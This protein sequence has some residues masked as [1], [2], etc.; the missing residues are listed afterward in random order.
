MKFAAYVAV[1]F[2]TF[3]HV[4]LVPF[5]ISVYMCVCFVCFCLILK[6]M[7]FYCYVY[8]FLLLCLCILI[9]MYVLFCIFCFIMLFYVFFVC[10][11]VLN[12]CQQVSTK[13]QLTN[14]SA[15]KRRI[16]RLDLHFSG[17]SHSADWYLVTTH[18]IPYV[19]EYLSVPA[20]FSD[21]LTLAFWTNRLSQKSLTNYH[22][23]LCKIPEEQQCHLHHRRSMKSCQL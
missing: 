5:F 9:V 8:I 21:F 2:I 20:F 22:S 4:L 15:I 13:L 17:I 18:N 7:Y 23:T 1:L 14:I 3:F 10:K 6:I 12:Y 16:A 19:T 11:C